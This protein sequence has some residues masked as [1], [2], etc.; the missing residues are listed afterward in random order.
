MQSQVRRWGNSLAVRIPKAQAERAGLA[1]GSAVE[2]AVRGDTLVLK[3]RSL[4]LE[5][6][7][8]GVTPENLHGEVATGRAVGKEEW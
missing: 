3:K 5:E 2:I 7:L 6:L 8:T 4:T 1:E